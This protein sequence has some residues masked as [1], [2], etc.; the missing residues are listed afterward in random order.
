MEHMIQ[1]HIARLP[2]ALYLVNSDELQGLLAQAHLDRSAHASS[3]KERASAESGATP[4]HTWP[5]SQSWRLNQRS[6]MA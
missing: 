3:Q 2:E 1:L 5:P 6:W 4:K